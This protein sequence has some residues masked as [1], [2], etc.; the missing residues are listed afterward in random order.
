[1]ARVKRTYRSGVRQA[2][3]S[4]TRS[5][6]VEAAR[7]LFVRDGF[8]ATTVDA[9]AREA[10]VAV[11]TVYATFGSKAGILIALLNR[12]E[13]GAQMEST[14]AELRASRSP[15]EQ[16]ALVAR[17]NRMLYGGGQE[18]IML[19]VASAGSDPEVGA[20][21]EEGDRR[22]REG[23]A[24]LVA[25]WAAAGK[26]RAGLDAQRAADILW[27]LSAPEVYRLLVVRSGWSPD[28]YEAWLA[29]ALARELLA[30]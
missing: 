3:A 9:I 27:T 26:L 21:A 20:W 14:I 22:R 23:Q 29:D 6:I 30:G 10:G 18:V 7:R 4:E 16:A 8:S 2:Q 25:A 15:A 19:A 5:R 1:M 11:P 12:L 13:A 17:F 28:A 24:P